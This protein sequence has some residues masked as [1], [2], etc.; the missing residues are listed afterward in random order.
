LSGSSAGA[1]GVANGGDRDRFM[2]LKNRKLPAS[3]FDVEAGH[4]MHY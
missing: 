1:A 2:I 3:L 4:L